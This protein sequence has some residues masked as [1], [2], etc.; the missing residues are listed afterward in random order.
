MNKNVL[1]RSAATRR[2]GKAENAHTYLHERTRTDGAKE[3]HWTDGWM[4]G[5]ME[6]NTQ[7]QRDGRTDG[8]T[9]GAHAHTR[10]RVH[11]PTPPRLHAPTPPRARACGKL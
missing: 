3:V 7:G 1:T 2:Q 9:H 5:W 8:W 6:G 10:A 4:D 11:A